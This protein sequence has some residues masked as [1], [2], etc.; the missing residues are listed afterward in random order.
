MNNELITP[1]MVTALGLMVLAIGISVW[2]R[3]GLEFQLAMATGRTV[4]QLLVVGYFLEAV[5][6]I[7]NPWVVLGVVAIMMTIA[8]IVARNRISKK[9]PWVLPVVWA[10][11]LISTALTLA[12]TN[13]LV[14]QA[15]PWYQPRYLIP[16]A[17]II[18]GNAMN[19]AALAG[20][21]LVSTISNSQVEI[22]THLCLGATPQ[23]AVAKYRKEAIKAGMIPTINTM[24]VVGVV[25]L[26]GII[27]GQILSGVRPLDAAVYQ[28]LIMFL[29]AFT[30]LI[31][32]VFLTWGLCRQFFNNAGQL[33]KW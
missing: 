19:S 4:L 22:E 5:F 27:T 20:E 33:L 1:N 15:E 24:M 26:P 2:Q 7:N 10:S 13:L 8:A 17:G 23:E 25:T 21:R 16:L 18:L 11:I 9:I 30:T 32:T 3:L 31:T 28:M 14:V 12:Y 29:L 6:E